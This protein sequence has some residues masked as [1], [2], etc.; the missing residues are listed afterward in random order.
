MGDLVKDN[1]AHLGYQPL[2]V[3]T[4]EPLNR[5]TLDADLCPEAH[6]WSRFPYGSAGYPGKD[7]AAADHCLSPSKELAPQDETDCCDALPHRT[8]SATVSPPLMTE[9]T[10]L[11]FLFNKED[12]TDVRRIA[13][14]T[15]SPP[16]PH[17]RSP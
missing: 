7:P 1:P 17:C 9:R 12:K 8:A 13:P 15:G 10:S 6:Q 16:L 2:G 11:E 14:F 5:A 4:G 3:G